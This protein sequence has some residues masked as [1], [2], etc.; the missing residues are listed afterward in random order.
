MS[1]ANSSISTHKLVLVPAI[2]TLIVT[3]IRL[4][5]ELNGWSPEL[6]GTGAGGAQDPDN[7]E[8]MPSWFGISWLMPIFGLYFGW[9]LARAG[10]A[11]SALGMP[12]F[13][14]F[15]AIVLAAGSAWAI[16][17]LSGEQPPA[18]LLYV[19]PVAVLAALLCLAAWPALFF[20]TLAYG[21]YARLPVVVITY[22][23]TSMGWEGTH[24]LA[25][26]PDTP[27]MA[28]MERAHWLS[29]SQVALWIPATVMIGSLFGC[30]AGAVGRKR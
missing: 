17:E 27:E 2:I 24:Y 10:R 6:F 22:L 21:I 25:L 1:A 12:I 19:G 8:S 26:P 28:D 13:L 18:V 30:I 4:T 7:P 29:F 23:A 3:V 16:V 15:V 14:S 5:G 11:P 20:A 9:K